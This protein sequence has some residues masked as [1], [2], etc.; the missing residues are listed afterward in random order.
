MGAILAGGRALRFGGRAK[1]LEM[2]GGL[3]IIDRVASALREVAGGVL[4]VGAP[5]AVAATLPGCQAVS[6][7]SPGNGPLGAIVTALRAAGGDTL[8][9]AWDMPFVTAEILR[10]LLAA[11]AGAE[12]VLW[13]N[14]GFVEPLCALYR[15]A[16]LEPLATAFT[17]GERSPRA[18]LDMLRVHVLTRVASDETSP[19]TSVNTAEQLDA[20]RRAESAAAR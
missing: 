5:P 7:E 15:F 17:E 16:A 6:D 18:A 2:V 8:V 19:F 13:E 10:P 14:D 20:A 1:G 9:V 3:R 4:L 12:A 11:P